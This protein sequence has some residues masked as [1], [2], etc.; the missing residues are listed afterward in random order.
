MI[1]Y[2][3]GPMTGLPEFNYPAFHRAAIEW[4]AMRHTVL[5]PAENFKGD[6][7]LPYADY[8]RASMRQVL[9]ADAIVLLESWGR[10]RGACAEVQVGLLLGLTFFDH[11]AK[12][13]DPRWIEMALLGSYGL[14]LNDDVVVQVITAA[15]RSR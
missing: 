6:T 9:L 8:I 10:S 15:E 14:E 1:V 13:I 11:E 2:L 7:T 5:N 12:P 4:R 3:A